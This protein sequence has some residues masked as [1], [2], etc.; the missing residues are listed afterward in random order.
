MLLENLPWKSLE[1]A[2]GQIF[3]EVLRKFLDGNEEAA[4]GEDEDCGVGHQLP[5]KKRLNKKKPTAI[6]LEIT[7]LIMIDGTADK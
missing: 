1:A 6:F 3:E 7:C 5:I 2:L 4:V